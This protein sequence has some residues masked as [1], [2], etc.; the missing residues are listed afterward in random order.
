MDTVRSRDGTTIAYDR[1]GSGP[2]VVLVGGALSDRRGARALSDALAPRF[3]V[4][5]YDRRGRGDSSDT[6]PYVVEREIDDLAALIETVGPSAFVYG[7]SSG[8]VLS[9]RAADAG[10]PI[11]R[12][13]IYEPPFIIDDSRPALPPDY[14]RHVDELI[15]A[16]KN[17]EAVEYFLRTGPL[18]PEA[19]I[20]RSRGSP[21]WEGLMAMAPTIAY[22]N[23]VMDGTMA[24]DP[25]LLDR[26]ASVAIP[27][28]VLAGGASPAFMHRGAAA[29]TGVLPDA[30]MQVLE[31]QTHGA[32]PDVLA[33]VLLDFFLG[34]R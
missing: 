16:G 5:A 7:H 33:P 23:R 31:G 15:A 8:A 20:A 30:T 18:V 19:V 6:P 2:P 3:T 25:T 26:W 34:A 22:D 14:D 4:I 12:L 10:L 1:R 21:A 28:L 29:L 13:A 32:A 17:D 11:P 9:L 27:T 24:G